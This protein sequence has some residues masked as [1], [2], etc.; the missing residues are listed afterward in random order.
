MLLHTLRALPSTLAKI[1][2][3]KNASE[4]DK[5]V[6]TYAYNPYKMYYQ[7]FQDIDWDTVREPTEEMF[8]VLDDIA[9]RR[10]TGLIARGSVEN[11][12]IYNGDLIKLICNKDLDCGVST[13]TL[14]KVFGKGFIP[15]FKV[16]LATAVD[17]S[18]IDTPIIGQLKYN[19]TR[20]IARYQDG[21]V[22]LHTRNGHPFSF[23]SLEKAIKQYSAPYNHVLDGELCF[24]DSQNE[25]HAKVSGIVNSA[26]KGTPISA[27]GLLF[28]TF[29]TLSLREFDSQTCD[30]S[31]IYRLKILQSIITPNESNIIKVADTYFFDTREEIQAK[32]DEVIANGYEGLILKRFH[33]FYSYKRSSDW[34]K[35]KA[36]K[37]ATLSVVNILEGEGKYEGQIGALTCEGEV[38]GKHVIVDVGSGLSDS[39]RARSPADFIGKNVDVL[40]N[41]IIANKKDNTLSLFLPRY[42]CIRG[43]I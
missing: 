22:L 34:I 21:N 25:N 32:F 29:D 28:N 18:K 30:D 3:L 14:N 5:K 13:T 24:G 27:E 35:L 31:Y 36:I 1:E 9:N 20:V 8:S 37:D 11:Y 26:I 33:H 19:G 43:D 38:E 42:V 40:Y 17:I 6:F 7:K 4:I 41:E 39:D 2:A 10:F 16:Q 23:P 15:E 12:S